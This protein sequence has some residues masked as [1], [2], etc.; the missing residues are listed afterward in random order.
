[1]LASAATTNPEA[2]AL[3]SGHDFTDRGAAVL[4]SSRDALLVLPPGGGS[5]Y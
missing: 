2:I 3:D 1:M 4:P 5:K